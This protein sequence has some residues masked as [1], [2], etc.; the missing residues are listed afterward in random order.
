MISFEP[1]DEEKQ[2]VQVAQKLAME[3]IRPLARES[4]TNRDVP[5]SIC[6]ETD[7]LGFLS[8]EMPADWDGMGLPL[9]S[10]VQIMT[11][12]AYG[13]LGI[14]QGLR[15][16]GDA[17]SFIRMNHTHPYLLMHREKLISKTTAV[18]DL[19][20]S[21]LPKGNQ[22]ELVKNGESYVINGQSHPVRLASAADNI[23]IAAKDDSNKPLIILLTE[24]AWQTER[25]D[26]RLG[27]LAAEIASISFDH[28]AIPSECI[29]ASG[30]EAAD[31][32]DKARARV[33]ILEAAKEVG[34]MQAA[35]DYTTAYTAERKAFGQE[36]AK[37]Q[38]VS[39]R[40]AKMAIE[41]RIANHL[42]WDAALTADEDPNKAISAANRA[43]Y[44]AHRS[45]RFVA[46]SAVQLLGGHGFVQEYPVEKW[47]R[48]SEAQVM[49][50]G[51]ER[52]LLMNCG[53][54]LLAVD[55]GKVLS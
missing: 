47:M 8:M 27:L 39:F 24:P 25:G 53:E 10:Q 13:D 48:D 40:V 45:A 2:F 32:I 11:A 3:K 52:E 15:G 51:R 4:E 6:N 18:I 16:A 26:V 17:A 34:L 42:V 14:V 37:F 55:K 49:L 35:L 30:E 36:I 33:F 46:D 44:R 38:G 12:L 28:L 1:S 43:L 5:L 20:A 7:N 19:T 23:I 9:I 29:L 54:Q 22:P 21:D 50:Y 41:T 31:W